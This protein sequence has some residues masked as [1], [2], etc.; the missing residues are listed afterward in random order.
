MALLVNNHP[1]SVLMNGNETQAVLRAIAKKYPKPENYSRPKH[2]F[3]V[4][5]DLWFRNR[6]KKVFKEITV[7]RNNP[8]SLNRTVI[9]PFIEGHQ[10]GKPWGV[11][12]WTL[13]ELEQ[14]ACHNTLLQFMY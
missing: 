4:T 6:P 8:V 9:H 14:W 2:G 3:G 12:L 10:N 1:A 5:L 11:M 7:G 13:P